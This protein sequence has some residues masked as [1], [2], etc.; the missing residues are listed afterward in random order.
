[1]TKPSNVLKHPY[2]SD[3]VAFSLQNISDRW[4]DRRL[5]NYTAQKQRLLWANDTRGCSDSVNLR[6]IGRKWQSPFLWQHPDICLVGQRIA[7]KSLIRTVGIL[8]RQISECKSKIL[9]L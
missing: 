7:T 9:P 3:P 2:I 5:C 8:K 6:E 4:I 1:M